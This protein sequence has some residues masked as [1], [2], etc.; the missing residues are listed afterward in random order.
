MHQ[1]RVQIGVK[2]ML[3]KVKGREPSLPMQKCTRN[4]RRLVLAAVDSTPGERAP[5][6]YLNLGLYLAHLEREPQCNQE[7]KE[8]V[9]TQIELRRRALGLTP[10]Q[11]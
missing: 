1:L 2:P 11:S 9:E 3:R 5:S 6:V 7:A 8:Y 10:P 4:W